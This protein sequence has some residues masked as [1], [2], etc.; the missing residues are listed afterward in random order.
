[1]N[2]KVHTVPSN[3]LSRRQRATRHLVEHP[4]LVEWVEI[5]VGLNPPWYDRKR[6]QVSITQTVEGIMVKV[7]VLGVYPPQEDPPKD[8]PETFRALR[9]MYRDYKITMSPHNGLLGQWVEAFLATNPTPNGWGW[10]QWRGVVGG[11]PVRVSVRLLVV[12]K[13]DHK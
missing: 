12:K 6:G 13:K 1:M 8:D 10:T 7:S 9:Q 5:F 3:R 11:R 2:P 4:A